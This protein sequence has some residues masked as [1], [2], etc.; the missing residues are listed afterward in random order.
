MKTRF[1]V[2]F[3][4]LILVLLAGWASC[5]TRTEDPLQRVFQYKPQ[6]VM[7]TVCKLVLVTDRYP[8]E[9]A[10]EILEAAEAELRRQEALL[11][12]WIESSQM[13]RLNAAAAGESIRPAMEVSEILII[14]TSLK[15]PGFARQGLRN[16]V[17]TTLSNRVTNLWVRAWSAQ[18]PAEAPLRPR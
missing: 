13:S 18:R 6:G 8:P 14:G 2:L 12:T 15:V 10:N 7:G 16:L 17:R 11:S 1:P 4:A 5:K 9:S 3:T